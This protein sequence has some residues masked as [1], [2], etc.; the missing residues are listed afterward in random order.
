VATDGK[1]LNVIQTDIVRGKFRH[2]EWL[3]LSELSN[4][5]RVGAFEVR[6]ALSALQALHM[7][8]HV[9][10]RGYRVMAADPTRDHEYLEVRLT[11][12]LAAAEKVMANTTPQA[13]AELRRLA[14][15]FEWCIE[16]G[17]M[18]ELAEANHA[19]HRG[20]FALCDNRV[21]RDQI[22]ELRE[23]FIPFAQEPYITVSARRESA[24]EHHRMV[25]ALNQQDLNLLCE[26]MRSHLRRRD[27]TWNKSRSSGKKAR[28]IA[29]SG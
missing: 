1:L 16:N 21:M 28:A 17:S 3:R 10:K 18:D 20:F 2:G 11:L 4:L 24:A 6:K 5:Y 7:I 25:D 14:E 26:V 19:F 27:P 22:N 29:S 13:I 15:R 12:E 23:R 8:E 9:P